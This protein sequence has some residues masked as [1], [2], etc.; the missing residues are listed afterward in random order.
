MFIS[1]IN[2]ASGVFM[3]IIPVQ[4]CARF[5]KCNMCRAS[6]THH[7]IMVE[8]TASLQILYIM[9]TYIYKIFINVVSALHDIYIYSFQYVYVCYSVV[10]K[11]YTYKC[12][13]Q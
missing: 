10:F 12:I 3:F 13:Y 7:E 1:Y 8:C 4:A 2:I 11:Y 9:Y 6:Y 5:W